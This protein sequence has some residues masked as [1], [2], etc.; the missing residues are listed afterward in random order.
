MSEY[1]YPNIPETFNIG[2]KL[3]FNCINDIA[4]LDTTKLKEIEVVCKGARGGNGY[5]SS[6]TRAGGLGGY[7]KAIFD[8]SNLKEIYVIVGGEGEQ[9]TSNSPSKVLG[10][11]NGGGYVE[12]SRVDYHKGT[13]GGATDIRTYIPENKDI[14]DDTS[15][16]SRFIVAGGGGGGNASTSGGYAEGGHAGG[17]TGLKS[18]KRWNTSNGNNSQSDGYG[19]T[20]TSGGKLGS[21]SNNSTNSTPTPGAFGKG[22]DVKSG[23]NAMSGAGGGGWYGGAAGY[24]HGGAG[25]GGSSYI[26]GHSECPQKHNLLIGNNCVIYDGSTSYGNNGNGLCEITIIS[27]SSQVKAHCKIDG[28]IKEVDKM[29]VKV[30][31]AWKEVDSVYVKVDGNWKKSE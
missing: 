20:Q 11:Y 15:L 25:A 5:Y 19:G 27:L 28:A 29:S 9:G 18:Q 13:G 17:I 31:G 8:V 3:I 14:F 16:N 12:D 4:T 7:S 6:A 1:I 2:D 10:G 30:D 24:D 26:S 21:D 22:G 23:N